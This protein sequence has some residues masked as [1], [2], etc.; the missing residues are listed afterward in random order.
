MHDEQDPDLVFQDSQRD[1]H[2][3]F[4]RT[5][6]QEEKGAFEPGAL[7]GRYRVLRCIGGGGTAVV[8]A[9]RDEVL[10]REVALKVLRD[11]ITTIGSLRQRFL[12]ESQVTARF[13]HPNIVTLHDVGETDGR[14]WTAL[15]LLNGRTLNAEMQ[16]GVLLPMRAIE[17]ARDITDALLHAH[18]A[19]VVHRDLKPDNVFLVEDGTVRVL[20]FGIA[21][22]SLTESLSGAVETA[23][24][25]LIGTPAY[26]APEQWRGRPP[27]PATDIFQLGLLL[28][29]ALTGRRAQG[30]RGAEE[31]ARVML[32][33]AP[34]PRVP[35]QGGLPSALVDLVEACLRKHAARRPNAHEVKVTLERLLTQVAFADTTVPQPL[36]RST[37]SGPPALAETAVEDLTVQVEPAHVTIRPSRGA[38]ALV[39]N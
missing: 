6:P 7:V 37:L 38:R 39:E 18:G 29:R 26:M 1:T 34:L 17:I 8:Y 15:E 22:T 9:A 21:K 32:D 4:V 25:Q 30:V 13:N 14:P 12:F 27:T 3:G 11:D 16:E 31:L 36:F 23:A 24:G 20:D 28:F 10:G 33:S 2:S 19:G 35:A 5:L